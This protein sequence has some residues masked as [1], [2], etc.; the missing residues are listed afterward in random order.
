MHINLPG[1]SSVAGV[2][3]SV[4]ADSVSL[5]VTGKYK[6]QLPL[7][8]KISDQQATAKF[9][10]SK[11]QLVL[12]LPVAL[13]AT[14]QQAS[15]E[16]QQGQQLVQEVQQQPKRS[17]TPEQQ[18]A[19]GKGG[20]HATGSPQQ[21]AVTP[22]ALVST[23]PSNGSAHPTCSTSPRCSLS[24]AGSSDGLQQPCADDA[25][26]AAAD[27]SQPDAAGSPHA[28]RA[29]A[30]IMQRQTSSKTQNQVKWEEL[31]EQ[32]DTSSHQQDASTTE[33]TASA[34]QD[35]AVQLAAAAPV[36]A[37][38]KAAAPLLRPRLSSRLVSTLDFV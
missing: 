33:A 11:Q 15:N 7:R 26:A 9:L 35:A 17:G 34:Q 31:H 37:M 1:V 38:T 3:L 16:H 12:T 36:P 21:P 25:A 27:T 32:T 5:E 28:P 30:T 19:W 4:T 14:S 13:P 22:T 20:E 2:D 23:S 10:T 18:Q 8:H 6:L 29:D 24:K